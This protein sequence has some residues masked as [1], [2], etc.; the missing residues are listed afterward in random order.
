MGR[1]ELPNH[2]ASAK[3][4]LWSHPGGG[5]ADA[6]AL[7]AS[8]AIRAGSSPAPGIPSSTPL[9]ED[10]NVRQLSVFSSV[11]LDGYFTSPKG[12]MS[13]AH[14]ARTDEEWNAFVSGNAK[15]GGMPLFG[16]VTYDMMK[17]YWPTPMALK[18]DPVVA[19]G[20][21]SMPKVVFSKT[22]K[23]A[24]WSNTKVVKG[25]I[26]AEVRTM[27][28][29]SGPDMVILG[30]GTIVSQFAREGLIDSYQL[31]VI[32]L[33]IGE[34]RTLFEGVKNKLPLKLT[35]SRSFKNGNVV[36]TYEPVT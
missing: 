26:A 22:L 24:T 6:L 13:W 17:S 14:Q 19:A 11:T 34:G 7:G 31:V 21:N 9:K 30:S 25:N 29:A 5:M 15:G 10:R 8:G 18:N 20:M 12:D 32:P 23:E 28:K 35:G 16:R 3:Y 1:K 33:V 27:K 2:N 36:L 4:V